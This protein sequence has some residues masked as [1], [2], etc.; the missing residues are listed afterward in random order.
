M[1]KIDIVNKSNNPL[2]KY[3]VDGSAGMDLRANIEETIILKPLERRLIPTGV[4][5]SLPKGYEAQVRG[6]SGLA[7]KYGVTCLNSP[8]TV[9]SG[10]TGDVG[11]ILI[12]LSNEDFTINHGDRIAQLIVAKHETVTWNEVEILEATERGERGYGHTGVK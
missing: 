5:I 3:E 4:H 2:P 11:V 10:Y 7:I 6:R 1:L 9:D 8:G 12:N